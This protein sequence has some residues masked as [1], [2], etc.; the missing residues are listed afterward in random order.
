MS[1]L[2]SIIRCVE[3]HLFLVLHL[4]TLLVVLC[5]IS[6][7]VGGEQD[8]F[9]YQTPCWSGR[10]LWF[11]LSLHTHAHRSLL[12]PGHTPIWNFSASL[13]LVSFYWDFPMSLWLGT[14]NVL[15]SCLTS[16]SS[17]SFSNLKLKQKTKK[18]NKWTKKQERLWAFLLN[19]LSFI[20]NP[21]YSFKDI[22]I[23]KL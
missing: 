22:H 16:Q 14:S 10:T 13:E 9:W 4:H 8:S 18:Q 12:S 17:T 3:A 20:T 21:F 19:I 6:I 23:L 5:G 2:V 7:S 15:P 11:C 1:C